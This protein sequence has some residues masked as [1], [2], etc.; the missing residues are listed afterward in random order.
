MDEHGGNIEK[1]A[2]E[3]RLK[4][5]NVIDF[6]AN[7]NPLGIPSSIK[8]AITKALDRADNYPDPEYRELRKGLASFYGV[9]PNELLPDNGSIALIYLIPRALGLSRPLIPLP[10]FSE[11]EKSARLCGGERPVFVR[12]KKDFSL[13]MDRLLKQLSGRDS[14]F[15]GNP[16][17]PTGMMAPKDEV[18]R[19]VKEAQA[20]KVTVILDEVFIEFTDA[21][22]KNTLIKEAVKTKNLIILQIGRAHV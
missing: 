20:K 4:K 12:P 10:A 5:D 6:S 17:N 21:G 22:L 16:N 13:N 1:A 18:L 8:K 14:L 7:I 19:I 3:Y 2:R 11:Y 15:L 9:R